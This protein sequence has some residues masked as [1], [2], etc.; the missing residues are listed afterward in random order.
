MRSIAVVGNGPS[1]IGSGLGPKI[2]ACDDVLRFNRFELPVELAKDIGTRFTMWSTY[3]T[4]LGSGAGENE[5]H[6]IVVPFYGSRRALETA[7]AQIKRKHPKQRVVTIP[8]RVQEGVHRYMGMEYGSRSEKPTSGL[9]VLAYLT[10]CC[11]E[12]KVYT[13]G[14][15]GCVPGRRHYYSAEKEYRRTPGHVVSNSE[16][17]YYK[18]LVDSRL[19]K[20][21][22]EVDQ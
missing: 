4:T 15:D 7:V 8:D 14:F 5:L 17:A 19:V 16:Q 13:C 22:M 2:D 20:P 9:V 6:T 10:Q 1:L 12:Y 3:S 21:L 18:Q 11:P